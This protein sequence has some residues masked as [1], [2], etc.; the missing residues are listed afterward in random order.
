MPFR[1]AILGGTFDPFH[2]GHLILADQACDQL[3]LSLVYIV[4]A[5]DP[6]H[7]R[8]L[9][10]LPRSLLPD[11]HAGKGAEKA[12]HQDHGDEGNGH[13]VPHLVF[14]ES[15]LEGQNAQGQGRGR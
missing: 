9:H 4:P 14:D 8:F 12:D 2:I 11:G 7:F 6:P 15:F 5:G 13:G 1:V 10:G 3:G